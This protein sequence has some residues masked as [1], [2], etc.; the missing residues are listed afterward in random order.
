MNQ[1]NIGNHYE[2]S[3]VQLSKARK[4]LKYI[5][6]QKFVPLAKTS[7]LAG[8]IIWLDVGCWLN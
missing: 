6:D 8:H 2:I 1:V 5:Q 4:V 3:P 7:V